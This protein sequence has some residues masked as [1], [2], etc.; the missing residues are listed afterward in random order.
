MT[1]DELRARLGA[2]DPA[3]SL[4]AAGPERAARL[5]EDAMTHDVITESRQDGPRHRSP[6]TWLVAAAAVLVIAGVGAFAVWNSDNPGTPTPPIGEAGERT[7]TELTAA[8]AEQTGRCLPP[9][10]RPL[11]GADVAFDGVVTQL[12]DGE[13]TLVPSHWYTGETTTTVTVRAPSA[14]MQSLLAAVDFQNGGRYLVA[15][16]EDGRVMLCGFSAP[17]SDDLAETYAQ[18]FG[19]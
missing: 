8:A 4:P 14:D 3:A 13:A 12:V 9:S 10:P 2:A 15:A 11:R 7:E 5:M 1:D 19:G 16:D 18:A 17:Y 6:L